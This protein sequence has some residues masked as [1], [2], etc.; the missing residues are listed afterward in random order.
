[1]LIEDATLQA[2][3]RQLSPLANPKV[4]ELELFYNTQSA[5]ILTQRSDALVLVQ[6]KGLLPNQLMTEIHA[7][8]AYYDQEQRHLTM[9]ISKSLQLLKCMLPHELAQSGG[10]T[11]KNKVR[12]LNARA[13]AIMTEWYESHLDNPY[14]TPIEKEVMAEQGQISVSQVKAW[15][16][17]KR[18]RSMNTKPKREK[19]KLEQQLNL[20]CQQIQMTEYDYSP[21]PIP[22]PKLGF[23]EN[24]NDIL[25]DLSSMVHHQQEDILYGNCNYGY[26]FSI[27]DFQV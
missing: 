20:I 15:F 13:V 19:Q 10:V 8:N 14:P 24:Y 16:A 21:E 26:D 1:L 6:Q 4:V 5:N 23:A 7:I 22:S 25:D 12:Q 17:N 11:K 27:S 2:E 3:F 18:N 9:R